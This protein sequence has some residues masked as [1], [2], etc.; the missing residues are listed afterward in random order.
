MNSTRSCGILIAP[1]GCAFSKYIGPTRLLS[2]L[3]HEYETNLPL[4]DVRQ[5]EPHLDAG[6]E[7]QLPLAVGG[8]R[9]F[10]EL[11]HP[12]AVALVHVNDDRVEHLA[13]PGSSTAASTVEMIP[14]SYCCALRFDCAIVSGSCGR[15]D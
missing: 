14:A 8:Y 6:S 5:L 3:A 15:A 12:A 1:G 2:L 11:H 13:H 4:R 7:R 10:P 9:R